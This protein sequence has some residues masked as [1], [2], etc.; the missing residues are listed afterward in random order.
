MRAFLARIENK[1]QYSIIIKIM[2]EKLGYNS[3]TS[4]YKKLNSNINI[5]KILHLPFDILCYLLEYILA[6]WKMHW[7]LMSTLKLPLV[8]NCTHGTT[9]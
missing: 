6:L 7:Q 1:T 2:Y 4:K 5:S 8:Q 9:K 3:S